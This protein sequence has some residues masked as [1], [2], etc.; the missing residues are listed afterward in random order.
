MQKELWQP[1]PEPVTV[2]KIEVDDL[3]ELTDLLKERTKNPQITHSS[4]YQRDRRVVVDWHVPYGESFTAM[5]GEYI[6][7]DSMDE[8][9]VLTQEQLNKQYSHVSSQVTLN[10]EEGTCRACGQAL[11]KYKGG[12][13]HKYSGRVCP[14]ELRGISKDEIFVPTNKE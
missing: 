8:I 7:I 12:I 10:A 13:W 11:L 14:A 3:I 5:V 1:N 4:S 6:L 9:K 2:I